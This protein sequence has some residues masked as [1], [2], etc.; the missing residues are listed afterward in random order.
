MVTF[1]TQRQTNSESTTLIQYFRDILNS[2]FYHFSCTPYEVIT[3]QICI[4]QKHQYLQNEKRYSKQENVIFLY[5]E[6]SFRYAANIF[7]MSYAL[8]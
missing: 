7:F 4:I 8:Q 6:R 1:S 5:F 3:F 2:V